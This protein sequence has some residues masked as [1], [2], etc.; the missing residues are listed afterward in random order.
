MP[1]RERQHDHH[2]QQQQQNR[3]SHPRPPKPHHRIVLLFDLDCF[4]AQCERVRLGLDLD[5]CLALLQYV[6]VYIML[7]VVSDLDNK[8]H[9]LSSSCIYYSFGFASCFFLFCR[10][11]LSLLS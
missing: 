2:Q 9:I 8:I 11:R 3:P 5:V 1:V 7:Y 10:R 6:F 4:Y